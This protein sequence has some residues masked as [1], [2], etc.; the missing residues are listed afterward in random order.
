MRRN[1]DDEVGHVRMRAGAASDKYMA[2]PP[3]VLIPSV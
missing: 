3:L 1:L 2:H